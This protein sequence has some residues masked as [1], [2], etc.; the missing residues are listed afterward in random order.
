MLDWTAYLYREFDMSPF[1][2]KRCECEPIINRLRREGLTVRERGR[3]P[4][5]HTRL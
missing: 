5:G 4:R 2:S 3:A 1:E